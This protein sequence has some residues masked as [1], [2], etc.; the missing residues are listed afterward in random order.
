MALPSVYETSGWAYRGPAIPV[1]QP[2][3]AD[4]HVGLRD[5]VGAGGCRRAVMDS[6]AGHVEQFIHR[7]GINKM[8]Q[9]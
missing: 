5:Q 3:D 1:L 7:H 8:H 9:C 2:N 4:V 6:E